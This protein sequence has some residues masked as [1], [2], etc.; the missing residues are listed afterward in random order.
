MVSGTPSRS[1]S[2]RVV[3]DVGTADHVEPRVH[4]LGQKL[5]EML[6]GRT[7]AKTE[8]HAGT[9]EFERAGGGCTFL[10]FDIHYN[11]DG[12]LADG[13]KCWVY[14]VRWI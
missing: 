9:H 2:R 13:S 7:A 4:A 6:R 1:A 12:P 11:R 14:L 10:S 8:P 5:D 3:S